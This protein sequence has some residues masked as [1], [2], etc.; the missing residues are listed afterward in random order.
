MA[1]KCRVCYLQEQL[2]WTETMKRKFNVFLRER[3]VRFISRMTRQFIADNFNDPD[4]DISFVSD[5]ILTRHRDRCINF[6]VIAS[7]VIDALPVTYK[8][9]GVQMNKKA[10]F[11]FLAT[12]NTLKPNEKALKLTNDWLDVIAVLI[13]YSKK[14]IKTKIE[15]NSKDI[16]DNSDFLIAKIVND[17]FKTF[18]L[19]PPAI[20]NEINATDYKEKTLEYFN[21]LLQE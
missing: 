21:D 10:V 15:K 14:N 20:E 2:G 9:E 18:R 11:D 6:D 7:N 5:Y 4:K 16:V 13:Q 1:G 12:F 17:T 8:K 3:P 19:A